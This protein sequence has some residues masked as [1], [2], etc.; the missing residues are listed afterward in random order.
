M[1]KIYY[2][3]TIILSLFIISSCGPGDPPSESTTLFQII[4]AAEPEEAGSVSPTL[5]EVDEGEE[6]EIIASANEDWVF[7]SWQ[8][9]HNGS[10]NPT[11]IVA[12]SDKNILAYFINID[13]SLTVNIEGE[14]TVSEQ[15]VNEENQTI[16]LTANP[17]DGWRFVEWRGD[18]TGTD[19]P[20][21]L[22]IDEDKE[23]TAVF[24]PE[25][26]N[27]EDAGDSDD[28]DDGAVFFN[29]YTT[30]DGAGTISPDSGEFEQGANVE[31]EATADEGW[32]FSHWDGDLSGSTNPETITMDSDKAITAVFEEIIFY[33]LSTDTDGSGSGSVS[34]NSGDYEEGTEVELTAIPDEES[35]FSHWEGD[36]RGSTNPQSITMDSDKDIT[37]IFEDESEFFDLMIVI[38][39]LGFVEVI[40]RRGNEI[41]GLYQR[42]SAVVVRAIPGDGWSF[43]R[44]EGDLNG[45]TNPRTINMNSD[46]ILR[47]IFEEEGDDDDD[48]DDDD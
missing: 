17:E 40:L 8:G 44:W 6:I 31:L 16:Q 25:D 29:L 20:L 26:D 5:V 42:G 22:I 10:T 38:D 3:L 45:K 27:G 32:S 4:I 48:D 28:G 37:A 11:R 7:F 30:P 12:D 2:S 1:S 15:M 36:L 46:K 14:G 18:I 39:G 35:I 23:V 41:N 47:A 19:N 33:E 24:E 43:Y 21:E 34:P 9:D 13:Y